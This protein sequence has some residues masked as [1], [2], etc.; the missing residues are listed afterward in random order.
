MNKMVRE[1]NHG[2][3]YGDQSA[4]RFMVTYPEDVNLMPALDAKINTMGFEATYA[5]HQ[6]DDLLQIAIYVIHPKPNDA[7]GK[8]STNVQDMNLVQEEI[9]HLVAKGDGRVVF[10]PQLTNHLAAAKTYKLTC[11]CRRLDD[12]IPGTLVR[13][14]IQQLEEHNMCVIRCSIELQ[15]K[16]FVMFFLVGRPPRAAMAASSM[17][18]GIKG[19][20]GQGVGA[21]AVSSSKWGSQVPDAQMKAMEGTGR[22]TGITED[23][24]GGEITDQEMMDARHAVLEATDY[25]IDILVEPVS[26]GRGPLG[27]AT[28]QPG[29]LLAVLPDLL[30]FRIRVFVSVGKPEMLDAL[31][32]ATH[33]MNYGL[34]AAYM[35]DRMRCAA[36]LVVQQMVE[37]S[38]AD[39]EMRMLEEKYLIVLKEL[40]LAGNV[41]VE[42]VVAD[43]D[44]I[45]IEGAASPK[46]G[47]SVP[48]GTPGKRAH[49]TM[50]VSV[51]KKA[52]ERPK[53]SRN[54]ATVQDRDVLRL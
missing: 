20:G 12:G 31:I 9:L 48:G 29:A 13:K 21:A 18:G 2:W 1:K 6:S 42:E 7:K 34:V 52:R 4:Y 25:H 45:R 40:Q 3:E 8:E 24:Q 5:R 33:N 47:E 19:E 23:H 36:Q 15:G 38:E 30:A 43:E 54:A 44:A 41:D 53:G 11:T 10:L 46:A 16:T 39:T 27:E 49:Q 14:A 51:T 35:D 50:G 17:F 37:G 28:H 26:V 22:L 32:D